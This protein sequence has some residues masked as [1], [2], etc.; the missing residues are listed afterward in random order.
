MSAPSPPSKT[1][2]QPASGAG[3]ANQPDPSA[4]WEQAQSRLHAGEHLDEPLAAAVMQAVLAQHATPEQVAEL[5][6]VLNARATSPA[7]LAG[8][9]QAMQA[10]AEAVPLEADSLKV[11]D[12]CGTGGDGLRTINIST[13]AAIV[14]AGAGAKV[15]KHGNRAM[16]SA[17][18]S[19]D[20][21][22]S[23]GLNL[24]LTP[25]QVADS[26]H[27]VGIGFCL[28]PRFHPAMAYV[29]PVRKELGVATVFN[30]LG[31]LCNPARV[32]RQIVGTSDPNMA[33]P[34]IE[35]LQRSGHC[36]TMVVHG[37]GGL[38]ELS[39]LGPS[40]VWRLHQ[41]QISQIEVEPGDFGL[42]RA[43]LSDLQGGDSQTNAELAGRV[44]AGEAGPQRD[45][46]ALN[47]GAALLVADQ[48]ANLADGVAAAQA[49]I[50]SGQAETTLRR[51]REVSLAAK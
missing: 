3:P 22:E 16:S 25:Q 38:D 24:E 43:S 28:A 51:W 23:L 30:F 27:E 13:I 33:R 47:A 17:C 20:V 49:A 7:E 34:L 9:L 18:G 32:K 39:T 31:P 1:A 6:L 36:H 35:A 14:A 41:G 11:I 4:T 21:L 29:A 15:C 8:F 2:A 45:V 26:V 42:P 50:D 44:L 5:L 37:A 48:V 40:Q 19:A 10:A 46:V 12:T